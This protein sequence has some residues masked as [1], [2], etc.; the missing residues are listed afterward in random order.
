MHIVKNNLYNDPLLYLN[1][2]LK[3]IKKYLNC[4]AR[5]H[6]VKINLHNILNLLK[7]F[8][9]LNFSKSLFLI[10]LIILFFKFIILTQK[11]SI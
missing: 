1:N 8:I 9:F 3:Y 2:Y 7:I 5:L 4:H 11:Y 6:K 10:M